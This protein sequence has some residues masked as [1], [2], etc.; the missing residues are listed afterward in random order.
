[1][2]YRIDFVLAVEFDDLPV[3]ATPNEIRGRW[4]HIQKL[5]DRMT[6]ALDR[7]EE[8]VSQR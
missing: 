8:M 1:M 5:R 6:E 3:D 2:K 4:D 7:Y